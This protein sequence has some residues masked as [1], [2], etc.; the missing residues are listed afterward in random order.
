MR[1][2]SIKIKLTFVF[3]VIMIVSAGSNILSGRTFVD[4]AELQSYSFTNMTDEVLVLTGVMTTLDALSA[5]LNNFVIDEGYVDENNTMQL[6]NSIAAAL[7]R[8]LFLQLNEWNSSEGAMSST[9][10]MIS[11]FDESLVPSVNRFISAVSSQN[12]SEATRILNHEIYVTTREINSVAIIVLEDISDWAHV[13][14]AHYD[15]LF[16]EAMRDLYIY[17]AAAFLIGLVLVTL[18]LRMLSSRIK[19]LELISKDISEGKF[20]IDFDMNSKDEIGKLELSL[21]GVAKSIDSVIS[22]IEELNQNYAEGFVSKSLP[23]EKFK[24]AY[25]GIAVGVNKM[26]KDL[27]NDMSYVLDC[28]VKV[29]DGYSNRV[30]DIKIFPN[31]KIKITNTLNNAITSLNTTDNEID[32]LLQAALVGNLSYRIDTENCQNGYKSLF[33]NLNTLIDE[34]T[35]PMKE[36]SSIFAEM[37]KG[38][39]KVSMKNEYKGDN[40]AIQENFNSTMAYIESY[41]DEISSVLKQIADKNLDIYINRE[42]LGDFN[43]IKSSINSIIDNFD[44]IV[45]E[46]SMASDNVAAGSE[47]ISESS[48]ALASDSIR[49]S[50]SIAAIDAKIGDMSRQIN[51][52]ASAVMESSR[53]ANIATKEAENGNTEMQSMLE[54]I[55]ILEA[56]SNNI[57]SI[58]KVIEDIAF[59]TNILAINAAVEAARA[60]DQGKGFFVVAEEVRDLAK[61]SQGA[62][63]EIADLIQESSASVAKSTKSANETAEVLSSIVNEINK[64]TI[65]IGQ[66]NDDMKSQLTTIETIESDVKN[67]SEIIQNS[68][69]SSSEVASSSEKLTS[70]VDSFKRLVSTF[71]LRH[72]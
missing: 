7:D 28:F 47:L 41:I 36:L 39:I 62:A 63:Q 30:G 59:Q 65:L 3:L 66:V 25:R 22:E 17:I 35:A 26:S 51:D 20:D 44:V 45:G 53:I 13:I 27:Q 16:S 31:E 55:K 52:T 43:L 29:C 32:K 12:V 61:R 69:N 6:L 42:Y 4:L 1:N 10:Q 37:S 70:Q 15:G 54:S 5:D 21:A 18:F 58:I 24:G 64:S 14:K 46:I 60:G 8:Y 40:I 38:N 49:Q 48:I 71:K 50:E 72:R 19:K 23:I 67:I 68:S 33:E 56:S 9:H 2:I 34:T 11:I 57:I